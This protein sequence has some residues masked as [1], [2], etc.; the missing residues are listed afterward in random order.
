MVEPAQEEELTLET[1]KFINDTLRG[2][3]ESIL[4]FFQWDNPWAWIYVGIPLW[5]A[6]FY[7][8]CIDNRKKPL[9]LDV[10]FLRKKYLSLSPPI[11]RR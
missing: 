6:V 10:I 11:R 8:Y 5:S 4:D 3:N 2:I 9:P 1:L 7:L